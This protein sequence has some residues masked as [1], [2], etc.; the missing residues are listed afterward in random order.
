MAQVVAKTV[1]FD[2]TV[3]DQHDEVERCERSRR[4]DVVVQ[5]GEYEPPD[6]GA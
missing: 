6:Y 1:A 3:D 5:V 2:G 4:A